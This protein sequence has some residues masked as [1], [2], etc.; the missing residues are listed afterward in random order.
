MSLSR[1]TLFG[2]GSGIL[3]GAALIPGA[4]SAQPQTNTE[5]NNEK[6][7]RRWYGLWVTEKTNWAPFD[8]LLTD[9]FTFTSAAPDDHISKATF[10]TD[11]WAVQVSHIQ[12]SDLEVV[13]A[14]GEYVFVRYLCHTTTGTTFRNVE[15]HHMRDG[16][17]ASLECYFGGP[18]FPTAS[19][20]HKS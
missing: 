4:V 12:R 13:V 11:C 20:G 3:V 17:I 15:L 2:T 16:K 10:K 1:R 8:A 19:E 9:D 7:V 5:A 6:V 18:G 14:K